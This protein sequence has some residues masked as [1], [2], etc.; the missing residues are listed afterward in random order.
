[1]KKY[2]FWSIAIIC[3]LVAGIGICYTSY[4]YSLNT[5]GTL[6]SQMF[7][8]HK[9]VNAEP[10]GDDGSS[11]RGYVHYP[12]AAC[13]GYGSATVTGS[14]YNAQGTTSKA[15]ANLSGLFGGSASN[16]NNTFTDVEVDKT[17]SSV[18]SAVLKAQASGAYGKDNYNT[19]YITWNFEAT[20]NGK[21]FS[22]WLCDLNANNVKCGPTIQEPCEYYFNNLI[23]YFNSYIFNN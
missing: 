14:A 6:V 17:L 2:L 10:G 7:S 13:S 1:M 4:S 20:M 12:T 23:A 19:N 16:S 18:P 11:D 22:I 9:I 8:N 21:Q 5:N 15:A 3:T